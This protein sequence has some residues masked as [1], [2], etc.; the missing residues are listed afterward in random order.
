MCVRARVLDCFSGLKMSLRSANWPKALVRLRSR[1]HAQVGLVSGERCRASAAAT[2][3]CQTTWRRTAH[4]VTPRL[5]DAKLQATV[6]VFSVAF[7]VGGPLLS[8][9]PVMLISVSFFLSTWST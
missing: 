5:I 7:F 2:D 4:L 6:S 3:A 1:S 9:V 8:G